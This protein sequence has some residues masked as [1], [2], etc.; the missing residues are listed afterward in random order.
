MIPTKF[1]FSTESKDFEL[2]KD[3]P[4]IPR[5]KDLINVPEFVCEDDLLNIVQAA[6]CWSGTR[7]VVESVEYRN[8]ADGYYT[9]II[10]W[11][12]D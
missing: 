10:V 12:E 4:Y 5:I 11:C 3:V 1:I 8:R 2:W 9:E 7:G 6:N